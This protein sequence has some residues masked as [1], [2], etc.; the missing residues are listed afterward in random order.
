M[1]RDSRHHILDGAPIPAPPSPA[2]LLA[3]SPSYATVPSPA[4]APEPG[5]RAEP[6]VETRTQLALS[7][8]GAA[9]HRVA[10]PRQKDLLVEVSRC[11]STVL[12]AAAVDDYT[13]S[14][15]LGAIEQHLG[16]LRAGSPLLTSGETAG[17]ALSDPIGMALR[18][19][20]A[21]DGLLSRAL[22]DGSLP[23]EAVL[24][25]LADQL[26]QWPQL[27][28]CAPSR[29]W[30][31]QLGHA[32]GIE[33]TPSEDAAASEG[34][35]A[36]SARLARLR[37]GLSEQL[38]SMSEALEQESHAT[39]IAM[40]DRRRSQ[41]ARR[42]STWIGRSAGGRY[43]LLMAMVLPLLV[44]VS[45]AIIARMFAP[46]PVALP[47]PPRRRILLPLLGRR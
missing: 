26:E 3:A 46:E 43:T 19:T 21:L 12:R 15:Q 42:S 29:S 5:A 23:N 37:L 45:S 38:A 40:L 32:V 35:H 24:A 33:G 31:Q 6:E 27:A 14:S 1:A 25:C 9:L 41:R 4:D 16:E 11:L 34:E 28:E 22:V 10:G 8:L 20:R 47:P 39:T 2:R 44:I 17:E 7:Q 13:A 18:L 36:P 30:W